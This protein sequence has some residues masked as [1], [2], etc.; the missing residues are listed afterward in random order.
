MKTEN[1]IPLSPFLCPIRFRR[2]ARPEFDEMSRLIMAQVFAAQNELGRLCDETVY[3]KDIALRLEAAGLG[4]VATEVPTTVSWREFTK[5]YYLDLV[6]QD[7]FI[8]ELKTVATLLKEHDSQLLNYL[9]L[10]DAPHG[11]LINLRPPS[12]EYHTVNAVVSAAERQVLNFATDRW[13]PQTPRCHELLEL[14]KELFAAWGAFLDCH[15]YEEALIHFLGGEAMVRQR[16]PLTRAGFPL[17]TQPVTLLTDAVA[18][19]ITAL[20]PDAREGYETHLRRLLALSP[21]TSLH[22]VNLHHH[23]VKLVTITR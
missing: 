7:A 6:V 15:L 12:V 2:L 3:Q 17:G 20:A 14:L 8:C 22:W 19:R 5:I 4:P 16:V 13:R 18:F 9:L 10:L 11:K 23:E 1:E 21:F